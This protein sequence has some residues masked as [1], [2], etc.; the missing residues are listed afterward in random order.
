MG[1]LSTSIKIHKKTFRYIDLLLWNR[2][3]LLDHTAQLFILSLQP[4]LDRRIIVV[5]LSCVDFWRKNMR[6]FG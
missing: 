3:P 4:L 2:I 6:A 5:G 1:I